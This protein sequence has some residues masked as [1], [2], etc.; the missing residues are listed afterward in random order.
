MSIL[1]DMQRNKLM[2]LEN[3]LVMYG[4]YNA[5]TLERL[6]KTVQVILIENLFAGQTAAAYEAY[7]QMHEAHGIRH[8]TINSMLY[9]QTIKDKYMEIYI[10][11]ISQ[12]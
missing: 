5:K 4:I 3:S 8:Y 9:L 2:H 11:F 6:V 7:W 1:A 12:L 10:E